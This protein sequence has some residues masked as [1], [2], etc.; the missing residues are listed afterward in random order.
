M[1]E[2]RIDDRWHSVERHVLSN[3][4][5]DISNV[6]TI[7]LVELIAVSG[8]MAQRIMSLPDGTAVELK[9]AD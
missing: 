3:K 4:S 5:H 8:N 1:K 2:N 7:R 6:R 9:V